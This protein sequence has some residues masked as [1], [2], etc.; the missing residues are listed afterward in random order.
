MSAIPDLIAWLLTITEVTD[1][2][3]D[4]IYPPPLDQGTVS[5]AITIEPITEPGAFTTDGPESLVNPRIQLKFYGKTYDEADE[6]LEAVRIGIN[7]KQNG[8]I[9]RVFKDTGGW[10]FDSESKLHVRRTDYIV[11]SQEPI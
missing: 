4:R 11:W 8:N 9:E 7:G 6:V 5:P 3:G 10:D 2:V 1:L